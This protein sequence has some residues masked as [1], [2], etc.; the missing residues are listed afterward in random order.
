MKF[1]SMAGRLVGVV[2]A[3]LLAL[4]LGAGSAANAKPAASSSGLSSAAGKA[5]P[6]RNLN[7]N[8]VQRNGKL[9]MKGKVDP[10]YKRRIIVVQRKDCKSCG[11]HRVAKVRTSSTSR[12][13]Y[14]MG[15]PRKG[16]WFYRAFAKRYNG[17]GKSWSNYIYRTYRA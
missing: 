7:D 16:A 12:F 15:A 11:W 4:S 9:F 5:L 17:Y 13:S 2:T 6:K 10:S 3:L 14:Q 1:M 8:L